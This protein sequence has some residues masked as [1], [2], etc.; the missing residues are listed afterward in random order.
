MAAL[1]RVGASELAHVERRDDV[2]ANA[3]M[4]DPKSQVFARLIEVHAASVR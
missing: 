3:T 4:I 1:R 2:R